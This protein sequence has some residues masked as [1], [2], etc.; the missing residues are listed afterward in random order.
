MRY[1]EHF[2]EFGPEICVLDAFQSP[3]ITTI[4]SEH[5]NSIFFRQHKSVIP[6][7]SGGNHTEIYEL[8]ETLTYQMIKS[9]ILKVAGPRITDPPPSY[10]KAIEN[11]EISIEQSKDNR[12]SS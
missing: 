7:K 9:E 8:T 12:T 10:S 4:E 5:K 6:K 11:S 2:N 3:D 1:N